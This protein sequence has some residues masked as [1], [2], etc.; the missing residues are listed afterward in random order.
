MDARHL[1]SFTYEAIASRVAKP[2]DAV[3]VD[4]KG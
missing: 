1:S 4:E 3:N 2:I